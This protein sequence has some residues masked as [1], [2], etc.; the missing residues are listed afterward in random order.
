MGDLL[1]GD[2]P[3]IT[4]SMHSTGWLPGAQPILDALDSPFDEN[5]EGVMTMYSQCTSGERY[6]VLVLRQSHIAGPR[7]TA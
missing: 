3:G 2:R 4:N 1:R 6:Q 5:E 7:R